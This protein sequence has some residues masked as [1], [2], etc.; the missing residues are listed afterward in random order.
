MPLLNLARR[1]GAVGKI[2]LLGFKGNFPPL[3]KRW[4]DPGKVPN[5]SALYN[6]S[7]VFTS[8]ADV[9]EADYLEPW[10]QWYS[11]HTGLPYDEHKVFYLTD[12]P[13]ADHS[14]I[15]CRLAGLGKSVMNCG[16]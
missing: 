16:R 11:I 4:M 15:W 8:I 3:L 9:S 6:S 13:E 14:D 10:I 5:F 2:F 7:Q 12:G 1:A